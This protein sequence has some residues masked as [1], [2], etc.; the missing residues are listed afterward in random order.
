MSTKAS[1]PAVASNGSPP[2]KAAEKRHAGC[3]DR[4]LDEL[5]C[6]ASTG[7]R[8][9][10]HSRDL[11]FHDRA[12][13]SRRRRLFLC[14]QASRSVCACDVVLK[15]QSA[16]LST[17][18]V[19]PRAYR[20]GREPFGGYFQHS[21]SVQLRGWDNPSLVTSTTEPSK[22]LPG[23]SREARSEHSRAMLNALVLH[24]M[25][26]FRSVG[27]GPSVTVIASTYP[28]GLG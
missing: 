11:S 23:Q 26:S 15:M 20:R 4:A 13:H 19:D 5:V 27:K 28:P 1:R 22:A 8:I 6:L 24:V 10:R 25:S 12:H 21:R 9:A 14:A 2:L 3:L 7:Y 18:A 16:R 17:L